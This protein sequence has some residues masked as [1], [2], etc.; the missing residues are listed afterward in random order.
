MKKTQR[1]YIQ[2][3]KYNDLA[4]FFS[5]LYAEKNFSHK[6]YFWLH[7]RVIGWRMEGAFPVDLSLFPVINYALG[8]IISFIFLPTCNFSLVVNTFISQLENILDGNTKRKKR[9]K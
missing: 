6:K 4:Y 3:W 1:E 9:T 5:S 8:A 2:S 7:D